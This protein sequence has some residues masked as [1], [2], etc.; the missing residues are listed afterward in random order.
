MRDRFDDDWYDRGLPALR[1]SGSG[2]R[3]ADTASLMAA[4]GAVL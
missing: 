4:I 1:Y 2:F 3:I